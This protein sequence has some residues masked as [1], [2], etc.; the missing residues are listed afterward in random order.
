MA[1]LKAAARKR[2]PAGD[3]AEPGK[4]AYPIHDL[5]HARNA[6]ARVSEFG[7]ASDKAKVR[8][9]VH[10]KYPSLVKAEARRKAMK[11]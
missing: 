10:R 1:I 11:G 6:L 8:A 7:T 3:F 9:A 5:A 4:R 2:L